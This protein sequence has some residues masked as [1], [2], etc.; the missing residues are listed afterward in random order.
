MNKQ[1]NPN[2]RFPLLI[3][4]SRSCFFNNEFHYVTIITCTI[5][6]QHIFKHCTRMPELVHPFWLTH[7][8]I[9]WIPVTKDKGP[10]IKFLIHTL[11]C[12]RHVVHLQAVAWPDLHMKALL[13]WMKFAV[14]L[15]FFLSQFNGRHWFR[16]PSMW[17][18]SLTLRW[19]L[20]SNPCSIQH[21]SSS[22]RDGARDC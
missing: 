20:H 3:V 1:G 2:T 13:F 22:Q 4:Q 18:L 16:F 5:N 15:H 14:C 21:Y 19:F 6:G 12:K 10:N 11:K 8:Q 17:P 7:S 9:E